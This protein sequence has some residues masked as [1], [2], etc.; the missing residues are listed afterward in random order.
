MYLFIYLFFGNMF[1]SPT[2]FYLNNIETM[3]ICVVLCRFRPSVCGSILQEMR[4]TGKGL[5]LCLKSMAKRIRSDFT[6]FARFHPSC[7]IKAS[8]VKQPPQNKQTNKIKC[9]IFSL[10]STARTCV[11]LPSFSWTTKLCTTMWSLFSSM[12]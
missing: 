5:Y 9:T 10:R 12:L 3:L 11:Y 7:F 1:F 2:D 8:S 6:M 4:C